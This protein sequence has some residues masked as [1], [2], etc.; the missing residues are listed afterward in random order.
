[1]E[2]ISKKIPFSLRA[3]EVAYGEKENIPFLFFF[4][5]LSVRGWARGPRS[6]K[7]DI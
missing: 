3:F 1:M 2:D 6:E 7:G 5:R 4:E